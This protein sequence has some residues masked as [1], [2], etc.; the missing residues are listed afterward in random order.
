M[1]LTTYKY[2]DSG[3]KKIDIVKAYENYAPKP[4]AITPQGYRFKFVEEAPVLTYS[5]PE[6][7]TFYWLM[8]KLLPTNK[9][10][11]LSCP[12]I[13]PDT[14]FYNHLGHIVEIMRTDREGLL[15]SNKP[16]H[17]MDL[18]K[19]RRMFSYIVRERRKETV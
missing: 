2:Y 13:F 6:N 1:C 11:I 4:R 12:L 17:R 15:M 9:N 5:R 10:K 7:K 3:D 14:A 16:E 18:H 8:Q 19:V